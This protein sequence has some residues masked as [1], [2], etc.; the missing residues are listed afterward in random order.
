[1]AT[2]I[3]FSPSSEDTIKTFTRLAMSSFS[4]LLNIR[5]TGDFHEEQGG[6]AVTTLII[7]QWVRSCLAAVS[8]SDWTCKLEE[9]SPLIS[10]SSLVSQQAE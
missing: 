1:M 8:Q 2:V 9:V 4:C 7:I 6:E 3:V 10:G 5:D